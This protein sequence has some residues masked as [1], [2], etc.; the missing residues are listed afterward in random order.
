MPE[1]SLA[2]AISPL[3]EADPAS[4]DTLISSGR[5]DEIFNK[6]AL[7]LTDGDLREVVL[8][9]RR[10]RARFLSDALLKEQTKPEP[11]TKRKAAPKTPPK[12]VEDALE[13][14]KASMASTVDLL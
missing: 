2:P 6:P 13:E 14:M 7:T 12:S 9:Y 5:L 11:G 3:L 8:Y 10:E 1:P 4:L